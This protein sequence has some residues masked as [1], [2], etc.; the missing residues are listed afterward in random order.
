[1]G[2]AYGSLQS[3]GGSSK[4]FVSFSSPDIR[5]LSSMEIPILGG[6]LPFR[7]PSRTK[8]RI[9]T[10]PVYY[11]SPK[12]SY[13]EDPELTCEHEERPSDLLLW[14]SDIY[15]VGFQLVPTLTLFGGHG[16]LEGDTSRIAS[17]N[18]RSEQRSKS[19]M[20]CLCLYLS[21]LTTW[22]PYMDIYPC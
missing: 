16:L 10:H 17:P 6:G 13:V 19:H 21:C 1:M 14:I 18:V 2:Y 15:E 22:H 4:N 9:S 7:S 3:Q 11:R 12:I 8:G 5:N 20:A